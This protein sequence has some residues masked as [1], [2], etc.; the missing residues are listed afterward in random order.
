MYQK[1][2][3]YK[4][5]EN[6]DKWKEKYHNSIG[7]ECIGAMNRQYCDKN[8]EVETQEKPYTENDAYFDYGILW[9]IYEINALK[10][11]SDELFN[12][13]KKRMIEH[14]YDIDVMGYLM[15]KQD[16]G[17]WEVI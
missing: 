11:N 2:P 15:K 5:C 14:G 9:A 10:A 8:L 7:C 17:K 13:T 4:E 16:D 3:Y 6:C 12:D 1:Y